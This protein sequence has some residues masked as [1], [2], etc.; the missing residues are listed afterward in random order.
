MRKI[1]T[2]LSLLFCFA[3][4]GQTFI[5]SNC[6]ESLRT[7]VYYVNYNQGCTY[8]W[9]FNSVIMPE[10]SNSIT[11]VLPDDEGVSTLAVTEINSLGCRGDVQYVDIELTPC[12]IYIPNAFT[13]NG[14]SD[15]NLFG[16]HTLAQI[17]SFSLSIF[18]RWGQLIYQTSNQSALWDGSYSETPCQ[19][20]VYIYKITG[21]ISGQEFTKMGSVTLL[22]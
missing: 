14:D 19:E 2:I 7:Q 5:F 6:D 20:G 15:N 1:F 4:Q 13:P 12:N 21:S 18:N 3:L 8:E 11:I 9:V 17:E 10:T 16:V 22:R